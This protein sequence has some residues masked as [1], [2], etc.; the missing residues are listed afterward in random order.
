MQRILSADIVV[1]IYA[2]MCICFSGVLGKL[3]KAVSR[4]V[5]G[6]FS[7]TDEE[8]DNLPLGQAVSC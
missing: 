8:L 7:P 4:S 2:R 3:N 6:T 1:V 5:K